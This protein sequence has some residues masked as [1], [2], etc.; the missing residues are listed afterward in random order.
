MSN[1][2]PSIICLDGKYEPYRPEQYLC[3]KSVALLV[4]RTGEME[5]FGE[6]SRCNRVFANIPPL[7]LG[8]HSVNLLDNHLVVASQSVSQDKWSYHTL[9]DARRGLLANP[10][11]H[12]EVIGNDAPISHISLIHGNDLMLLGGER[13]SQVKLQSTMSENGERKTIRQRLTWQKDGTNFDFLIEDACVVKVSKNIHFVLGGK[14]TSS[15]QA[16][17]KVFSID[18][19][20]QTVQEVGSL[21]FARAKHACAIIE[22]PSADDSSQK[23]ILVTG[24]VLGS[25]TDK[26]EM[27]D[28]TRRTSETMDSMNIPRY[29]H[30]MVTLGQK[31]FAMGGV[32]QTE[33]TVKDIEVFDASSKS[34]SLHSS[35][36]LSKSTDDLAVTELPSTSVSCNQGC[37]CG[38]RSGA[39]IVG[40]TDAQVIPK[41]QIYFAV[42]SQAGNHPW[43]G[44]LLTE[45]GTRPLDSQC[46]ATMVGQ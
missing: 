30:Q 38:V 24:G 19:S 9:W 5:V 45:K 34:W 42:H 17:S 36:L 35:T 8:R 16:T 14:E 4:S 23:S 22:S 15:D 29:N 44:L 1:L 21:R 12:I 20:D 31:V 7:S 26:D 33:H 37:K 10:W 41:K 40:G 3:Q 43:L 28:L 2:A 18:M 46:A 6:D 25:S 11:N 39:R 13:G 27:F 32:T